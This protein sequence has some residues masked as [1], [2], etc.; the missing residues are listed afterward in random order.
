MAPPPRA[1]SPAEVRQRCA[2]G[3][4]LVMRGRRLYDLSGF[5]RLHPGGEQLLR[6]RAGSDVSAALEGPPH[7]HSRNARL[8]LE[9]YYLGEVRPAPAP[10]PHLNHVPAPLISCPCP[11][12]ACP[13]FTSMLAYCSFSEFSTN[14]LPPSSS[15]LFSLGCGNIRGECNN[16]RFVVR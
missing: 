10:E 3:A 12:P 5:V 9:Q 7:R 1:Y 13:P 16:P 6:E 15:P 11:S 2:Q 14:P 4:C 8:W